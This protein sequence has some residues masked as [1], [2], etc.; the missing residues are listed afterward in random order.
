MKKLDVL[1][2]KY[3]WHLVVLIDVDIDNIK[4]VIQYLHYLY[5]DESYINDVK[6]SINDGYN[7]AITITNLSINRSLVIIY[8]N[9]I[10]ITTLT[11]FAR[12]LLNPRRGMLILKLIINITNNM[13]N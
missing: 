9:T 7:N 10:I 13:S 1:I 4:S 6:K 12:L 2:N 8:I 11:T 5:C 3:N